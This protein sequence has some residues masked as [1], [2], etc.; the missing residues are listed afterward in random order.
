MLILLELYFTFFKVALFGFGGGYAMIAL[1][2]KEVI[3]RAWLSVAEFIDIVAIAEMTPGPFA[4]NSATY[5]GYKMA[6]IWGSLVAT[7]G[8]VSPSL[9]FVVILA[10]LTQ[11]F[12]QAPGVKHLLF[13]L[14]PAVIGFI[15]AAACSVGMHSIVDWQSLLITLGVVLVLFKTKVSPIIL[16]ALAGLVGII[17]F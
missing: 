13:V 2:E 7:L 16:I 14:R 8:V 6:S 9:I 17:L 10:S 15:F 12:S 3:P 1:L 5:I 4:I 11:K